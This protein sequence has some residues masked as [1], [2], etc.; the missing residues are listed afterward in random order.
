[1]KQTRTI[2][3]MA[4]TETFM[5]GKIALFD[6]DAS[7]N[8]YALICTQEVEL[9]IPEYDIV[10]I[11]IDDIDKK[12]AMLMAEPQSE[13]NELEQRKQ[14]LLSIGHYAGSNL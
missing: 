7:A 13:L 1:M 8:G 10:Q 11:Q 6:F 2:Y 3:V 4:H 9:D 14:E 5:G 12:I